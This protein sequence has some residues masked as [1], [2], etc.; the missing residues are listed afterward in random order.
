MADNG[1]VF[2]CRDAEGLIEVVDDADARALYFGTSA[3][4]SAMSREEPHRLVLSYTRSMLSGL[5]FAREPRSVLVLGL[6]G[7]SLPRFLMHVFPAC[8][9]DVVERRAEVVR[10]AH[11]Y[12]HLARS[13]RLR[14]HVCD[15]EV[16]LGEDSGGTYDL[17]LVDLH[18]DKGTAPLVTEAGFFASCARRLAARGV[19]VTNL[20]TNPS[21]SVPPA[22]L[23][24]HRATFEHRHLLLPVPGRG[25]C[26]LLGL[27]FAVA[28]YTRRHLDAKSIELQAR[29][30]IDFPELLAGLARANRDV[31]PP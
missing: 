11:D 16:F 8:R 14:I 27:S 17:V 21:E 3:R 12:F 7:G 5:L 26:V 18:D 9:V 31:H 28:S 20:W 19:L 1:L 2:S 22:I 15:A 4:Q 24:E 6:G 25:N 30:G 29:L 23:H 13:P 10:V